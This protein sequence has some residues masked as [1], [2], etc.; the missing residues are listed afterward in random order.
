MRL[1]NA[2][3]RQAE[4]ETETETDLF[5]GGRSSASDVSELSCSQIG[6]YLK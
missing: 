1:K 2:R 3:E 5:L 4:T 6:H